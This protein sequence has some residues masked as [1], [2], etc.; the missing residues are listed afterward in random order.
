[1]PGVRVK[2]VDLFYTDQGTGEPVL[3]IHGLTWDHTLWDNQVAALRDRY[4][5]VAVDLIGHGES[6]DVDYDYSFEDL[7]DYM[8]GLLDKIGIERAHVVGLSMGGMTALPMALAHPRRVL[9]LALLDTDAQPEAPEKAASYHQLSDAAIEHGWAAI[10]EPVAGILFGAPYLSDPERKQ[11]AIEKLS[12]NGPEGVARALRAVTGRED[13]LRRL[14]SIRVPTVVMVGE[15]D[16]ATTPDKAEAIAAA[17]PGATLV[18][19]PGAGHHS[20]LENPAAVTA[21]LEGHLART[22]AAVSA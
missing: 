4:R 8:A 13:L 9:S 12:E 17:I 16:V 1:M 10:A 19:I 6:G 22:M 3:F 21:A 11:A 18:T 15:L 7:A 2:D 5:C 20:P 14:G